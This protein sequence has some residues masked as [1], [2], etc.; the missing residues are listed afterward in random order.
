MRRRRRRVFSVAGFS[1]GDTL[2]QLQ[3]A[4]GKIPFSA[5]S[6]Y[7]APNNFVAPKVTEWS[8]SI[9]HPVTHHDV[10]ARTYA[11]QPRVRPV[12]FQWLGQW[13]P[14]THQRDEQIL[15]DELR[16]FAHGRSRSAIPDGDANPDPG[17]LQLRRPH[18]S[19]SP[20]VQ[21]RFSRPDRLHLVACAGLEYDL[22]SVQPGIWLWKRRHRPAHTPLF[23]I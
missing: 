10:L 5:P 23:P 12:S 22:Q 16:R 2:T 13:L 11:R 4:L 1:A 14:A 18:G 7:S 15:R 6:Y 8:L 9:E 21:P 17:I 19:A 20:R 3:T